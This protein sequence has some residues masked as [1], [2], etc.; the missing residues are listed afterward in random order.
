[1]R[2]SPN[3]PFAPFSPPPA[4]AEHLEGRLATQAWYE[5]DASAAY[6]VIFPK[7]F[8]PPVPLA[9]A[10]RWL[11]ARAKVL[12]LGS[13]VFDGPPVLFVHPSGR[14]EVRLPPPPGSPVR[15]AAP[16]PR[17]RPQPPPPE[18]LFP[19]EYA[20]RTLAQAFHASPPRLTVR[21]LKLRPLGRFLDGFEG[22]LATWLSDAR[23]AFE[24]AHDLWTRFADDLPE[25]LLDRRGRLM[26]KVRDTLAAYAVEAAECF[27]P[28][29]FCNDPAIWASWLMTEHA[30]LGEVLADPWAPDD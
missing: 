24:T 14:T 7:D 30:E 13:V 22:E 1:M 28:A 3:N 23:D 21:G 10:L 15:E 12:R 6:G 8:H 25:R 5:T 26:P 11:A 19:W 9:E 29:G 16:L 18:A 27:G 4:R 20:P 2:R 17:D